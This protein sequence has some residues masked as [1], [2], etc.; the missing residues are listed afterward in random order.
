MKAIIVGAG[1]GGLTAALKLHGIGWDVE[2][3]ESVRQIRPLGVGINLLPHGTL[4]LV[5]L[6]LADE[7][8]ATA[9]ET[10]VLEFYTRHGKLILSDPRGIAAGF[11]VP[12]YSIHRGVLQM[13]LLNGFTARAGAGKVHTGCRFTGYR[14]D[15][16]QVVARFADPDT[17]EQTA[18]ACADVLIGAD[19]IHSALRA[20]FYPKEGPP[21]FAGIMMWRGAH[22]Q[23]PFADGRTWFIAGYGDLKCV[24]YPISANAAARG[25]SLINWVAE[26]RISD[27]KPLHPGDWNR[28]GNRDFI[29]S[30]KG[31][32]LD[33]LDII[34]LFHNT[35]AVYEY[36]M[37]DRD[38]VPRWSFG[39]VTLLGDA[40]HP[41]YPV[42]ANGATQAIL[43]AAC[44]ADEL[45][46]N[47]PVEALLTYQEKR[48]PATREVVLS[49]R[50]RGPEK[51]LDLVEQRAT[52]PKDRIEDL[53]TPD[54][55][56]EI[57]LNYRRTAGFNVELVNRRAR[58][59]GI[60]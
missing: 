31:F 4:E 60:G 21:V 52:G 19:G 26:I 44:L 12:Q 40:A 43:D 22:E 55:L 24:V 37:I 27:A 15:A 39:R 51:V 2:V 33:Y 16:G 20:H 58:E 29:E 34:D 11:P 41:M 59:L 47:P 18:E 8:A 28:R 45:A 38:P 36:P 46:H 23:A 50:G 14:E 9:I 3:Y 30:F 35:E 17:G 25:Q 53:I 56:Q 7:L 13:L 10:R 42:G 49:N 48:L 54:E 5:S 1:I 32:S 6:G 57:T